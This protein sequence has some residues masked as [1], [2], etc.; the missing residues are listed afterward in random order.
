L[1]L[2]FKQAT[3][4]NA[5]EVLAHANKVPG[6]E[7]LGHLQHEPCHEV[8]NYRCRRKRNNTRKQHTKQGDHLIAGAVTD[9]QGNGNGYGPGHGEAQHGELAGQSAFVA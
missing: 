3:L 5:A 8:R 6:A 1:N 4:G 9:R 7:W 2:D